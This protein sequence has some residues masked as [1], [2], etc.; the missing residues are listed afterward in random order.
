MRHTLCTTAVFC[1]W[2][3]CAPRLHSFAA[4]SCGMHM[5]FG[6][7]ALAYLCVSGEWRV[8]QVSNSMCLEQCDFAL[9][10]LQV[11]HRLHVTAAPLGSSTATKHVTPSRCNTLS[12]HSNSVGSRMAQLCLIQAPCN[13]AVKRF[14]VSLHITTRH[15]VTNSVTLALSAVVNACMNGK[16]NPLLHS[17]HF[18]AL[19][20]TL[21][22]H[23]R[24]IAHTPNTQN[25]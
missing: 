13:V 12:L 9:L 4:V 20:T 7:Q 5:S 6:M 15:T 17:A 23:C 2:L 19:L 14:G 8:C 21:P 10:W 25:N 3:M 11:D 1:C 22:A 18:L 16:K 24:L